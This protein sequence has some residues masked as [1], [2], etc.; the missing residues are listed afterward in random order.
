MA[1]R[2]SEER[3]AKVG[4][5]KKEGVDGQIV[6]RANGCTWERTGNTCQPWRAGSYGTRSTGYG[7]GIGLPTQ[8]PEISS[9]E[10]ES[11]KTAQRRRKVKI[12][13]Q[14]KTEKARNHLK[15]RIL[16]RSCNRLYI[17]RECEGRGRPGRTIT[18]RGRHEGPETL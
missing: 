7:S 13:T 5:N 18:K 4:Q 12:R 6:L 1:G 8:G 15:K 11:P 14:R 2:R 3:G 9:K 17:R 16:R 10:A